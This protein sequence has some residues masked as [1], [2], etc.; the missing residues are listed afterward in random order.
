[1]FILIL[2]HYWFTKWLKI[3]FINDKYDYMM[4]SNSSC[5]WLRGLFLIQFNNY[6]YVVN[7][8]I[9]ILTTIN[10]DC[11]FKPFQNWVWSH[12]NFVHFFFSYLQH[13]TKRS[14]VGSILN[15]IFVFPFVFDFL[16]EEKKTQ[17]VPC[18]SLSFFL[19]PAL[20]CC[21]NHLNWAQSCNKPINYGNFNFRLKL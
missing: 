17:I 1:M 8:E 11:Y 20:Y 16:R 2:F 3:V 4:N 15:W 9:Q 18:F 21:R 6:L 13:Q 10:S 7:D 5:T 12:T 19:S 14:E